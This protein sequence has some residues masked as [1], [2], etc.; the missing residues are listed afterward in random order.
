MNFLGK[1]SL[2]WEKKQIY[3]RKRRE[4]ILFIHFLSTGKKHCPEILPV[5]LANFCTS[6]FWKKKDKY[7]ILINLLFGLRENPFTECMC[8]LFSR[9]VSTQPGPLEA[10]RKGL[11]L[12]SILQEATPVSHKSIV[13]F[14]SLREEV[15]G[16]LTHAEQV[17]G[18]KVRT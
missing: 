18:V 2:F 5:E 12:S 4:Q 17:A 9:P 8:F 13:T 16:E 1:K 3:S 15:L 14:P 6:F 11:K 7:S 10:L